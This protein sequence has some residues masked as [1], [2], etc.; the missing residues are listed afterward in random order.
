MPQD[1]RMAI[2]LQRVIRYTSWVGFSGMVVR[3]VLFPVRTN[4]RWRP[5]PSWIISNGHISATAY[6]IYLYNA[7]IARSS[8]RRHCLLVVYLFAYCIFVLFVYS[9]CSFSTLILLVGSFTCKTVSHITYT[10]LVETLDTA[11]TINY[12]Q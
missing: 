3:M 1:M 6:T 2:S 12:C 11:Q 9:L 4:P 10:V 8:L 7:R 5:P